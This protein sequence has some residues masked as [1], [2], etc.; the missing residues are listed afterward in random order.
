MFGPMRNLA[1]SNRGFTLIEL[2][3][4]VAILG[5]LSS[6]VVLNIGSF[7]NTGAVEAANTEVHQVQTSVLAHM[8][9]HSLTTWTGEVGPDST[10][11]SDGHPIDYLLNP[12]SLQSTYEVVDGVIR[13][14]ELE[15]DSKWGDLEFENGSWHRP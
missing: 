7:I 1:R 13:D 4:V 10:S 15:P 5:I 14:A 11:G 9:S 12:G 6:V 3:V 2:L 8:I